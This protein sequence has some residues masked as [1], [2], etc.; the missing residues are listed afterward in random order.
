VT[1]VRREIA[2]ANHQPRPWRDRPWLVFVEFALVLA[3]YIGRRHHILKFSATPYLFV[4]AW[5]SLRLRGIPFKALGFTKYRTWLTTLLLGVS[6]GIVLEL[7]DLFGKQPLLIHFMGKAPDLSNFAA[8]HG[9]LKFALV[10]VALVWI[11]A[12]FGEELVYRG[13]LMN[14]LADIG[15]GTRLAWM[16][17]VILISALF[18]FAHYEQGL[19]GILEEGSDGVILGLLYLACRRNLAVPI[20]AHGICDTIDIALLFV[21]K[22][23][24]L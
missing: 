6:C 18:G 19:T 11:V 24:G 5:S 13:Y 21:G 20:V 1:R 12:A 9:N 7:F 3:V 4:L 8:V 16:V 2:S 17:S 10:M 22:Y 23:P 15:G 14:R